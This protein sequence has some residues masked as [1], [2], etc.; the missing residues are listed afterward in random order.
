MDLLIPFM[1]CI[2]KIFTPTVSKLQEI[3][4]KKCKII[5]LAFYEKKNSFMSYEKENK[6]DRETSTSKKESP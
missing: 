3:R 1:K 2:T 6:T 5:V 4:R